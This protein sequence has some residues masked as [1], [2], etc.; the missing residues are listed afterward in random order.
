M[1]P[2]NNVGDRNRPIL[3]ASIIHPTRPIVTWSFISGSSA[4]QFPHFSER[5]VGL[6]QFRVRK[7]DLNV[8]ERSVH[9]FD[10]GD[11]VPTFIP[12]LPSVAIREPQ[13]ASAQY[14]HADRRILAQ[15]DRNRVPLMPR[16]FRVNALDRKTTLPSCQLDDAIMGCSTAHVFY[17]GCQCNYLA[18]I[19][20]RHVGNAKHGYTALK[21]A[22]DPTGESI[23]RKA[24]CAS[25]G[26]CNKQ[27]DQ[28]EPVHD[29]V[30]PRKCVSL[31]WKRRNP[32]W[33]R[34]ECQLTLCARAEITWASSRPL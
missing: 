15:N 8:I 1:Y 21:L 16:T 5:W 22:L 29:H 13:I 30:V 33:R 3:R 20:R 19:H 31:D 7:V 11:R 17:L 28:Q 27:G 4:K 24:A 34:I 23:Q 10:L 6:S 25:A 32:T 26:E 2:S 12:L 14:F 9:V 18:C